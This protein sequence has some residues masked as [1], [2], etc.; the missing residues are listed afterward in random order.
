MGYNEEIQ[1][2]NNEVN[3]NFEYIKIFEFLYARQP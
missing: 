2:Y 3:L 1:Y